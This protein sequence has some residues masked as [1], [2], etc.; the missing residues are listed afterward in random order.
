MGMQSLSDGGEGNIDDA[1][2]QCGHKDTNRNVYG[3]PPTAIHF[4]KEHLTRSLNSLQT[5]LLP[6]FKQISDTDARF[7][8]RLKVE[9]GY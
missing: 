7:P 6:K 3:H 2:I 5:I 8:D 4:G 1:G 9:S